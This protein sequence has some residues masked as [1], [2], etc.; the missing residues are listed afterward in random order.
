MQLSWY[1][2][3]EARFTHHWIH[4]AARKEVHRTTA[5]SFTRRDIIEE[6]SYGEMQSCGSK[7]HSHPNTSLA[8][9]RKARLWPNFLHCMSSSFQF[10]FRRRLRSRGC[11]FLAHLKGIKILQDADSNF[12]G[13]REL[14]IKQ[15]TQYGHTHGNWPRY[16]RNS[17]KT[18]DE[19]DFTQCQ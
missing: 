19:F 11:I 18:K 17:V 1:P 6:P 16:R 5:V 15:D 9:H 8:I 13:T 3:F 4:P 7:L 10:P 2:M 14:A 12:W